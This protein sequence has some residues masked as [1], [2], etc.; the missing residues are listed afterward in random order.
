V[1][2]DFVH[3]RLAPILAEQNFEAPAEPAEA[4]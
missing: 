2:L 4:E 3:R 1:A